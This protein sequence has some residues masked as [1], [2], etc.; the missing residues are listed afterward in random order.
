[1]EKARLEK[2]SRLLGNRCVHRLMI[3]FYNVKISNC[4]QRI[5]EKGKGR[6][7]FVISLLTMCRTY[8]F[9]LSRRKVQKK[10]M[11]TF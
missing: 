7:R 10:E 5:K 2:E 1:M 8:L 3:S 9:I 6:K 4:L 11:M